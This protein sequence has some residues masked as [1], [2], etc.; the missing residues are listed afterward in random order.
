MSNFSQVTALKID[1]GYTA[2][3]IAK[4]LNGPANILTAEEMANLEKQ[5]FLLNEQETKILVNQA[6]RKKGSKIKAVLRMTT[7][8]EK[9][10]ILN[11]SPGAGHL[12]NICTNP[13]SVALNDIPTPDAKIWS[14][15]KTA[16]LK[17]YQKLLTML[18]HRPGHYNEDLETVIKKIRDNE[19]S[20][21]CSGYITNY[22]GGFFSKKR[23]ANRV[24]LEA[25]LNDPL[26]QHKC[27]HCY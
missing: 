18:Q 5:S 1:T 21:L 2:S 10:I 20:D 24:P 22:N 3:K 16:L 4:V 13:E 17:V 25:I 26:K 8:K 15:D 19:F 9:K 23:C 7:T 14:Q 27:E 12:I 6:L 11:C